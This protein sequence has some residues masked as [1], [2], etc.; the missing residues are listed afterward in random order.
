MGVSVQQHGKVIVT[1]CRNIKM[2]HGSAGRE[3][4]VASQNGCIAGVRPACVT[5]GSHA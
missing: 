3:V 4:L 5:R 1:I 2:R